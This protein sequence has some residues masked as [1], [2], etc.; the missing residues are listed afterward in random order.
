MARIN[1]SLDSNNEKDLEILKKILELLTP[2]DPPEDHTSDA[3][4][5]SGNFR[6]LLG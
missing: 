1:I 4:D 3:N 5:A 2:E 6:D